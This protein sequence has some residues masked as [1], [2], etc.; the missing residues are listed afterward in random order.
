MLPTSSIWS[1]FKHERN[2]TWS[3]SRDTKFQMEKL[4]KDD[5]ESEKIICC[6]LRFT[7]EE[8]LRS[9]ELYEA[10]NLIRKF[11]GTLLFPGLIITVMTLAKQLWKQVQLHQFLE[12]LHLLWLFRLIVHYNWAD[13]ALLATHISNSNFARKNRFSTLS[14]FLWY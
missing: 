5:Q 3:Q 14:S 2:H 9:K 12:S 13:K 4:L 6:K 8:T 10:T 11:W 7:T 1:Y